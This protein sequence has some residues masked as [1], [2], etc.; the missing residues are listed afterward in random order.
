MKLHCCA[1]AKAHG[2]K[3]QDVSKAV[4]RTGHLPAAKPALTTPEIAWAEPLNSGVPAQH[5]NQTKL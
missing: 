4:Q 1:F 3:V 2:P 5:T